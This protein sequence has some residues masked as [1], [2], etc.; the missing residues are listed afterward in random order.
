ML[1]SLKNSCRWS[2]IDDPVDTISAG[3]DLAADGGYLYVLVAEGDYEESVTL[4][5]GVNLYAGF[6]EDFEERDTDE[7]PRPAVPSDELGGVFAAVVTHPVAVTMV[8]LAALVFG[9][10]GRAKGAQLRRLQLAAEEGGS[11]GF[12]F[13][14]PAAGSAP[15][16]AALRLK[17]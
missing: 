6:S 12:L 1:Q 11:I 3:I 14:P 16:V 10:V 17:A 2:T 8:F 7:R 4:A 15:S 5:D 9:W 13:R